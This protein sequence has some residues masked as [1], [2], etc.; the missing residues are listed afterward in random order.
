MTMQVCTWLE[1]KLVC[2]IL[3]ECRLS[4]GLDSAT[5]P[6][7]R[8]HNPIP[9]V[10]EPRAVLPFLGAEDQGQSSAATCCCALQCAVT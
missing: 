1:S 4:T 2:M 7:R 10:S 5:K 3:H 6:S 9:L 8:F